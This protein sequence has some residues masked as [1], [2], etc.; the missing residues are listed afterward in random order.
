VKARY[1]LI[2][3]ITLLAILALPAPRRLLELSL[4]SHII[5]QMPTLVF[6][7]WSL[8]SGSRYFSSRLERTGMREELPD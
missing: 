5:V 3:A 8:R 1:T 7:G 4:V 2:C 6:C